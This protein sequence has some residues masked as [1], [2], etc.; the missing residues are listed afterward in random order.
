MEPLLSFQ[1]RLEEE[2]A[3]YENVRRRN[4]APLTDLTHTG[5]LLIALRIANSLSQRELAQR[6]GVGESQVSRDER[7]EYHG[8][9]VERAQRILDALGE[10]V[11]A[12]VEERDLV[13]EREPALAD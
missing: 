4:F 9:T 8:I 13:R 5:R 6:L 12:R 3:W 10:R 7:N 2:V 11:Q 1:A